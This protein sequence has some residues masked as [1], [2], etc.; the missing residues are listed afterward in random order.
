MKPQYENVLEYDLI[1]YNPVLGRSIGINET[2]LLSYL[3]QWTERRGDSDGWFSKTSDEIYL[4]TAL[5]RR[6]QEKAIETLKVYK[7]I[8][9]K[10]KGL[11]AKR[12][13]KVNHNALK[14]ILGD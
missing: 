13:F 8:E 9:V 14:N 4:E 2:I 6:M 3:I 5:T 10:V 7:L 1:L 11:P 12:Y